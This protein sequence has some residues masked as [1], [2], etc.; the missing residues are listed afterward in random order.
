MGALSDK[1]SIAH[2]YPI[3]I[4][5]HPP[6][7]SSIH[8]GLSSSID[9]AGI[10]AC[11]IDGVVSDISGIFDVAEVEW[12]IAI[13]IIQI[14]YISRQLCTHTANQSSQ[15][16]TLHIPILAPAKL[17]QFNRISRLHQNVS[18]TLIQHPHKRIHGKST[19]PVV[20]GCSIVEG[21]DS[22]VS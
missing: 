11:I 4:R 5:W 21:E 15:I 9:G 10:A 16:S 19:L 20:I 22:K 18:L 7:C 14:D 13:S 17:K 12:S 6:S 1:Q 3:A 2:G 8:N